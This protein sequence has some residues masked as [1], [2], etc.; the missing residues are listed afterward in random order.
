MTYKCLECGHIFEEGEEKVWQEDRGE[1]WGVRCSEEMS[2]CPKCSGEY[3]QAIRCALCGEPHLYEELNG[4]VCDECLERYSKDFKT[5][6]NISRG[7]TEMVEINALLAS[8]FEPSDIEAILR[9]YI[10][11]KCPDIDYTD[12][13]ERDKEWFGKE[14][15]KEVS[16]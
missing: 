11:D 15:I 2:G 5:C 6:Y 10:K 9:A 4:G 16:R 14:L 13:I 3:E 1:Y 12:Y 7:E 8:L